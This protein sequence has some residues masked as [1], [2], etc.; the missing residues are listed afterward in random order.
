[1]D[2]QV[3][4]YDAQSSCEDWGGSLTSITSEEENL[5]LFTRTPIKV[6]SCWAGMY[7]DVNGTLTW[8]DGNA[9]AYTRWNTAPGINQ[10]TT[11]PNCINWNSGGTNVWVNDDCNT[12]EL[13]CYICKRI[14]TAASIP[15]KLKYQITLH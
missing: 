10:S 7:A 3:N 1:M 11:P 5:L 15:G 6:F 9:F 13:K 4:W 2:P 14:L 12:M 8:N